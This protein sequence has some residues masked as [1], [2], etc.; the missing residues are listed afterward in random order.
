MLHIVLIDESYPI[1]TRNRKIIGSLAKHYG[2]DA[3][4]SDITWDRNN[5][6]TEAVEGHYVYKKN[7]TYGNKTRKLI[8]LWGYRQ[9][10]HATIKA[11]KPDVIIASHWNNLVM[12]PKLDRRRQMFIYENLDVPTEAYILRKA[13][14][15]VEHW[16]LRRVDL[17]IHAS[18]FFTKLYSPKKKQLILENKPVL[19]IPPLSDYTVHNPIRIAFLGTLRYPDIM[20]TLIDAVKGDERFVLFFHGDGHARQYLE[21]HAKGAPNIVF[22]G[23]YDYKDIAKL[24][25][26]TD[27]VWAA[28]PNKDFNVVYAISNKFH[29]SL[30]FGIPTVYANN[31]CLGNLVVEKHI[32]FAVDPYSVE[33][34]KSLLETIFADQAN[35]Q[36]MS[37]DMRAF[38]E[39]QTTWDEDFKKVT[40]AIDSFFQ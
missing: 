1:N 21:E 29:E 19:Q 37:H 5:D 33:A 3:R 20:G 18:R 14:T 8:N 34:I 26:Q 2:S 22:T 35:L 31:T 13:S 30:A 16:H 12:V 6:Y 25:Q 38:G 15:T 36:K 24:Y 9:F 23:K 28:Y 27:I 17:T 11:L 40:D 39:E 7:S 10:C 4:L 32:G